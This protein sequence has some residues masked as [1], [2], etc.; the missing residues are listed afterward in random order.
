MRDRLAAQPEPGQMQQLPQGVTKVKKVV[1]VLVA[2][3]AMAG[4]PAFAHH[5]FAMFD[6]DKLVVLKGTMISFTSMNPHAWLSID[7]KADGKGKAERWDVEATA[8]VMLAAIGIRADT[9]K[10]GDRVTMGIRPLRDGRK[11]GSMVFIVTADGVAH[12]AKPEALGL[13]LAALKP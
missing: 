11:G 9:L 8:P 6:G 2:V 3:A 12:G 10:A 5:S 13:D 1:T 7:A 4:A